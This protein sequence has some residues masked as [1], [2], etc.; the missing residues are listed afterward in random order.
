MEYGG[1]QRQRFPISS[2]AQHSLHHH[3][4][5]LVHRLQLR[6]GRRDGK[7]LF[8]KTGRWKGEQR[9]WRGGSR[10]GRQGDEGG[11]TNTNNVRRPQGDLI[12][13]YKLI[14]NQKFKQK[15]PVCVPTA[16]PRSH[17]LL[18]KSLGQGWYSSLQ[19]AVRK[20]FEDPK[21]YRQ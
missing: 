21:Q 17:R 1:S 16:A 10:E 3:L 5:F 15:Y 4:R 7:G 12:L 13:L 20:A 18:R 9:G 6:S 19:A 8:N 11:S 14:K 2:P